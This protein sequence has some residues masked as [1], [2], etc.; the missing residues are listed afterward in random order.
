MLT[1]MRMGANCSCNGAMRCAAPWVLVML[2][3]RAL[4][5]AGFM[6]APIDGQL[7]VVLCNTDAARAVHHHGGR[8]HPNHHHHL[9]V[10]PTCPYA[11]SAG[12]APLPALPVLGPQPVV[13]APLLPTQVGETYARSGPSRQTFPRGPPDLA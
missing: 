7:A 5:P 3:L 4:V 9:Q 12:P 10:D 8:D 1:A 13:S 2:C 6:L 11:Q